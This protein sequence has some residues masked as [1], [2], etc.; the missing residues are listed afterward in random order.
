[1]DQSETQ[2]DESET[3]TSATKSPN[4]TD[5]CEETRAEDTP[6]NPDKGMER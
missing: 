4:V 1:M 5:K 6:L 2:I 3:Q